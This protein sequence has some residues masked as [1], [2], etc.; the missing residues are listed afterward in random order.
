[1]LL[2]AG[3]GREGVFAMLLY[4]NVG[5]NLRDRN[6]RSALMLAAMEGHEGIL[7]MLLDEDDIDL[8]ATG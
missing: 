7:A 4:E 2:A 5:I 8:N 6:N 3:E 1:M